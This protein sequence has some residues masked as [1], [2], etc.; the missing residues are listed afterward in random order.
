MTAA[1]LSSATRSRASSTSRSSKWCRMS[2]GRYHQPRKIDANPVIQKDKPWEHVLLIPHEQLP[3]SLRSAGPPVQVLVHGRRHRP[4]EVHRSPKPATASCRSTSF[5]TAAV[6]VLYGRGQAGPSR[7]LDKYR[8]TEDTNIIL[9]DQEW[10]S[11]YDCY[12][13]DDPFEKDERKRFKTMYVR[14]A[15]GDIYRVEAA[16]SAD[17]LNWKTYAGASLLRQAGSAPG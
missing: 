6:C 17:G 11:I 8:W 7:S 10:G 9:G 2:P 5:C 12:V 1:F 13:I 3:G 15:K 16:Y 4:D 14:I